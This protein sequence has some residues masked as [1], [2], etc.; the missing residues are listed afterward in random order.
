V[1]NYDSSDDAIFSLDLHGT[2]TSWNN[3]AERLFGYTILIPADR[4]DDEPAIIERIGRGERVDHYET[5]R[6]CKDGSL[7]EISLTVSP[8]KNAKG[9]I[10][11]ASKISRDITRRKRREAQLATLARE[12]EH[13]A[14][15]VLSV[16]QATVQLSQAD[17]PEQLKLVIAG[18][19]RA[20]SSVVSLFAESRWAGAELHALLSQELS[21][22]CLDGAPVS[23]LN[24][25]N[26]TLEPDTAQAIALIVHE[27]AT[28][29]AKYGA[30]SVSK[31]RV[32]VEWSRSSDSQVILRWTETDGPAVE[33]PK[34]KGFGSQLIEGMVGRLRTLRT[35]TTTLSTVAVA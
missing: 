32:D 22:Y 26:L 12:A 25:P 16:A 29:A 31:G 2:I 8:V 23:R 33:A 19:L 11:G 28:N 30:L 6:Q 34:R 20:L 10:I 24:G 5:I 3:G 18:R 15:N 9:Q 21:A 7:V 13:R 27:L 35:I 1:S 4:Q 14:R 17:T